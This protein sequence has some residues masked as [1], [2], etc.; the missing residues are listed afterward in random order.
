MR[1][2]RHAALAFRRDDGNKDGGG[3]LGS[4]RERERARGARLRALAGVV[5][6]WAGPLAGLVASRAFFFFFENLFFFFSGFSRI[7]KRKV[8]G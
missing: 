8:L 6:G 3:T 2:L 1:W 4:E 5:G 7:R